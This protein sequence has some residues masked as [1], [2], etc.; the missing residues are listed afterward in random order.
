MLVTGGAA[1]D[2]VCWGVVVSGVCGCSWPVAWCGCSVV[3]GRNVHAACRIWV[4]AMTQYSSNYR[5]PSPFG[6]TMRRCSLHF[7]LL[8][9]SPFSS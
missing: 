2:G 7:L 6:C 1:C 3:L 4:E 5:L 9:L 8:S